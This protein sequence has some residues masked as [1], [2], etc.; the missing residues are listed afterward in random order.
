MEL[1]YVCDTDVLIIGSGGAGIKA[2]LKAAK[3][4]AK[5]LLCSKKRFSQ[6]GATFYP[7]LQNFGGMNAVTR[8]D[9]GDS[10][11][12][13]LAEI[14]AA[15]DGAADE[16][17]ARVLAEGCTPAFRELEDEYGL[18]FLK[19]KTGQYAS[20]VCCFGQYERGGCTPMPQFKQTM[21]RHLMLAGVQVR[22]GVDAACLVLEGNR[23][24]GAVALDELNQLVFLRAKATVLCTGGSCGIYQYS[25]ATDD[26][27]G[28]GYTMALDA[29]AELVNMEFIQFIP[30][31][32]API[33]KFLFQQRGLEF[34]PELKN[35]LGEDFL[36]SY[37]PAGLSREECLRERSTHGPFSTAVV[38]RYFDIA[39]YEEWRAG[40]AFDNGGLML[41]YPTS[42]RQDQRYAIKSLLAWLEQYEVDSVNDGFCLIPHAQGFNGGI[43]IQENANAGIPGLFAAGETAGGPHGADR[44]GGNAIAAG[45]VFGSIAGTSAAAY[46]AS[47]QQPDTNAAE[48]Y[49]QMHSRISNVRGGCVDIAV[50]RKKIRRIMWENGAICRSE[51]RCEEGL[52]DIHRMMASF[53]AIQQMESGQTGRQVLALYNDL[54][55]AEILLSVME[56]RKESR[57]PHYRLDFPDKDPEMNGYIAVKKECEELTFCLH[58]TDRENRL[59]RLFNP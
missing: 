29:G 40:R 55:M 41:R 20:V 14:I 53:N 33:T 23:C 47:R 57:G 24:V 8:R 45:Q 52:T 2:A 21:W 13:L 27:T 46:A 18:S 36:P 19:D 44:L 58:R 4:G 48:A 26:L 34:M 49:A 25:L 51:R 12:Q 15:G 7:T 1:P 31:L 32:T 17:L 56:R 6:S 50:M 28:D 22:S 38:G 10:E 42:I 5:V 3:S 30:G 9:L 35:R 39:L 59:P 54:R 37:L 43:H 11:E 16:K